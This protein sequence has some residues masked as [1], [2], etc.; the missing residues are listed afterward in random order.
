MRKSIDETKKR[1][2][3]GEGEVGRSK[4]EKEKGKNGDT[5]AEDREQEKI[6]SRGGGNVIL[7]FILEEQ[8]LPLI[9][10]GYQLPPD[11]ETRVKE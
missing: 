8:L 4:M 6:E 2:K 10:D 11:G 3:G 1:K 5:E 9:P 7:Q